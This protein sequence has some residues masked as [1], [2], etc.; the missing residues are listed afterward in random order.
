MSDRIEDEWRTRL[1]LDILKKLDRVSGKMLREN[2]L[3]A[4][5][6]TGLSSS[7][8]RR[9]EIQEFDREIDTL[10]AMFLV[11]IVPSKLGSRGIYLTDLGRAEVAAQQ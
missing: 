3:Y 11:V 10:A 2:F 1:R 8:Y 5:I 9:A 6:N 7:G 4:D